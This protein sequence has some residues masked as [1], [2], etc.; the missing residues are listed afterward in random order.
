[1]MTKSDEQTPIGIHRL[2]IRLRRAAIVF[3]RSR[4]TRCVRLT[5]E[6]RAGA[7]ASVNDARANE[8]VSR[9]LALS[10]ASLMHPPPQKDVTHEAAPSEASTPLVPDRAL[11]SRSIREPG[12]RPRSLPKKALRRNEALKLPCRSAP[13]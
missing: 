4:T 3:A 7:F 12:S 8:R 5:T 2:R 11:T 1:M 9:E 13:A 6:A 10:K